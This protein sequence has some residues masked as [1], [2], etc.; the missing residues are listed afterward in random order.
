MREVR[1]RD[2]AEVE[3]EYKEADSYAREYGNPVVMLDVIKR[4]GENLI[5]A[6]DKI[7]AILDEARGTVL[8]ADLTITLTNDQS[9]DTRAGAI[10]V[11][12]DR[13]FLVGEAHLRTALVYQQLAAGTKAVGADRKNRVLARLVTAELRAN[14]REQHGETKRFRHIIVRAGFKPEDR[15]GIGTMARKHD[16]RRLEP[17]FAQDTHCLAPVHVGQADVHQDEIDM[18]RLGFDKCRLRGFN[19]AGFEFLVQRELLDKRVAQFGVVIDHENFACV[20]H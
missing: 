14:A 20:G 8:P 11:A 4:A 2:I 12:Q 3:F 1:L 7:N 13:R 9:D 16:D 6:S 5:I 19:R 18:P 17:V 15:I 10:E